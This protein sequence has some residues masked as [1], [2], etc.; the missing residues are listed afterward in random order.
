MWGDYNMNII[1]T[2]G[3]VDFTIEVE[4]A[5]RVLDGAV[6]VLC[7]VG[8]VQSQS[9]TVDRQMKRYNVPAIAFINKLDRMGANPYR[10]LD[11][12]RNKLKHNAAFLQLPIGL[13]S[14][15]KG[16]VDLVQERAIYFDGAY[17]DVLRYEEIPVDMRSHAVD[18]RAE[19]VEYLANADET[20][21][22]MFLMEETPKTEDII[23]EK[24]NDSQGLHSSHVGHRTQEQR[25][26]TV[27]GRD[28]GLPP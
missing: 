23:A 18:A 3:H 2:P 11:Q 1:D 8:G 20:I 10:V 16:L 21:G 27:T 26:S 9:M 15:T 12:L 19:L 24:S 6:L 25:C 7:A 5:L 13:E 17:G 28:N 4:R 14:N 22:E